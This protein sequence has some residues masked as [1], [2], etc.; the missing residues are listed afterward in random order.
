MSIEQRVK[1]IIAEQLGLNVAQASNESASLVGDLGADSVDLVELVMAFE[2]AFGIEISDEDAESV[3]TVR[4]AI[5]FIAD[6][7]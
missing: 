1:I 6:R 4:D 7:V 3:V 2:D 5:K